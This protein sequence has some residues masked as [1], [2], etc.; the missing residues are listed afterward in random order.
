[1]KI[2]IK[3]VERLKDALLERGRRTTMVL[4]PAYESLTRE[5]LLSAE[6]T[7]TLIRIEP[8]AE[9]MFL[10]MAVDGDLAP[11]E[12]D[13][14]RGAIRAL[15]DSGLRSGTIKVMLE[16]FAKRMDDEGWE[17]RLDSVAE[18]LSEDRGDAETAYALVGAVALADKEVALEENEFIDK[19]AERLDI[20]DERCCQLLDFVRGE[21]EL[22]WEKGK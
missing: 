4:S 2:D 6:E 5:G 16:T 14:I 10:M 13:V 15:T 9:A 7:Q 18:T 17:A 1:M 12:L 22:P 21:K 8:I 19:F 20:T 11:A 3:T